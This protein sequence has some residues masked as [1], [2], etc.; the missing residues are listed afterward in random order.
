MDKWQN[1]DP[2]I[3]KMRGSARWQALRERVL[4]DAYGLCRFC[5]GIAEEVHHIA[6]ATDQNFFERDNLA[7]VCCR[8]HKKIHA[9]YKC[10]ITWEMF[11]NGRN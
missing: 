6:M 2:A 5:G 9:A 8:C 3:Q 4:C 7:A 11:T 10:G 1:K